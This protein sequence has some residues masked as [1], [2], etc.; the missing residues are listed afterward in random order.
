LFWTRALRL[1]EVSA[2]QPIGF[3]QLPLVVLLG[4]WLFDEKIDRYT[5][6]GAAIIF[7]A[8]L[9]IAHRETV[10]ARRSATHAPIEG[11]KPGE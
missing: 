3:M 2:L 1:G 7:S 5:A 8:N 10:L 9:Y 11:A 6:L 4:G